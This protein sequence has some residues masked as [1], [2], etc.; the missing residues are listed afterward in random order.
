MKTYIARQPIFNPNMSVYGY[1]LLYRNND[2]NEYDIAVDGEFATK[3]LVS[4][5]VTTFGLQ[6]IS[7]AKYS[8]IN[9]TEKLLIDGLPKLL[10]PRDIVVEILENVRPTPEIVDCLKNLKEMKYMLAIDDYTNDP[11]LDCMVELADFVKVDFQQIDHR[12]RME[13]P[14]RPKFRGKI[15]LAEKVETEE[16]FNQ[17]KKNGYKLFQGFYFAKPVVFIKE[18]LDISTSTYMRALRELHRPSFS[19]DRLAALIRLDVNLT[20]KLLYRINTLNYYRG[21]RVESIRQAL[22]RMGVNELQRWLVLVL[23][24][25]CAPS[26]CSEFVK[27]ALIR[28][29]FCE[30]I[31]GIMNLS[32]AA[33]ENAFI[34]G[35]FSMIDS[36]REEEDLA[37][38]LESAGLSEEIKGALLGN[39]NIYNT[40]LKFV[41]DY[42]SGRMEK[43]DHFVELHGLDPDTVT[44]IYM[45]AVRYADFAFN[46]TF[47]DAVPQELLKKVSHIAGGSDEKV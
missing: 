41:L 42:E 21:R 8:F 40:I 43:I 6:N 44:K 18:R 4:N 13:L 3:S 19:Y 26:K 17:A 27:T 35:M 5:A 36:Q 28:G 20:Y 2:K 46:D 22:V 11:A 29:V 24:Q 37:A 47:I 15:M 38:V 9:F 30:E 25:D 31:A 33:G 16:E 12:L 32:P 34:T 23:L 1:E 39:H 45:R 10:E 7:D 14:R